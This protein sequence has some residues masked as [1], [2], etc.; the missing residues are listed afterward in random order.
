MNHDKPKKLPLA[1][2]SAMIVGMAGFLPDFG[3]A[4]FTGRGGSKTSPF[5]STRQDHQRGMKLQR[6]IRTWC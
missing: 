5:E 1:I 6:R 2:A 4:S 3:R